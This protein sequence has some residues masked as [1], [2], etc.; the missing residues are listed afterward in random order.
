MKL[1]QKKEKIVK[2]SVEVLDPTVLLEKA[3]KGLLSLSV[4]LGFE[5]LRQLMEEEVTELVGEKGKHQKGRKGYR[6]GTEKTKVVLG[7]QK[8]S[9]TRPRVRSNEGGEF[10]LET[11]QW[12]QRE[13]SLNQTVLARLLSGVSCRKYEQTLDADSNH[14]SCTSK[15]EVSRRFIAGMQTA[16]DEFLGRGL[17]GS[18]PAIMIDGMCVGKMT[19]VAAMGI[20]EG[21]DKQILGLIEGGSE[22]TEVVKALLSDLLE[23]GLDPTESRLYVIDGGKALAK[24]IK[25]TFGDHAVIQRCQV[26]KKRNVLSKLPESEQGNVGLLLSSAYLEFEY[27]QALSKLHKIVKKMETRFPSAAA[28]LKEGMEETLTVHRLRLP[29]LLR[30]TLS[31]TN[32]IESANSTCARI[33]RRVTHF[34]NGEVALRQAAAGFMEAERSFRRIRGYREI[35]ILQSALENLTGI[36]H[37]DTIK[38]A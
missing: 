11:L 31:N 38:I 35:P 15:S 3:S 13:D 32:P 19:I 1:Y 36:K 24:G 9:T 5:V 30:Q 34:K 6:H 37:K 29:G 27:D 22:N 25:D 21:G 2:N 7:G 18:Y 33:I 10:P 12:F 14:T 16:I 4:E 20:R 28:S 23:R 26:H 8:V 17:E